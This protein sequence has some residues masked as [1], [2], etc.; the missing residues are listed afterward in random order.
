MTMVTGSTVQLESATPRERAR[1]PIL[2]VAPRIGLDTLRLEE[3]ARAAGWAPIV[4]ADS[5]RYSWAASVHRPVA[6]LLS[7]GSP[8]WTTTSIAA[9]STGTDS[10]IIV[11]G[12]LHPRLVLDCRAGGADSVVP[13]ET[14]D[15]ELLARVF[16]VVRRVPGAFAA[17]TRFLQ[18][19]DLR[20]DIRNRQVKKSDVLVSLTTT[21]FKVL[22][23]LMQR[24]GQAVASS[25]LIDKIWGWGAA[26]G[27]NTLR[28]FIRRL[29]LKLGDPARSPGLIVSVR[30]FGYKFAPDV[31]ELGDD[32]LAGAS[33][34]WQTEGLDSLAEIATEF[35]R[36]ASLAE[37]SETLVARLVGGG[38][39]DAVA[40]HHVTDGR[41]NLQAHRGL[42][43]SWVAQ[44]TA[45]PA[46]EGLASVVAMR[47]S[48]EIQLRSGSSQRFQ[49]TIQML[50]FENMSSTLFL[51]FDLGPAVQGCIGMTRRAIDPWSPGSLAYM[52]ALAAVYAGQVSARR[53]AVP[54]TESVGTA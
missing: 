2:V 23:Y 3:M 32:G 37:V 4:V 17:G 47:A 49:R 21:E 9:L 16:A 54:T 25:E 46:T 5:T 51:P 1:R 35:A 15:E 14:S 31:V 33:S 42:S 7:A 26:D 19:G 30:G 43:E 52:R 39:V 29:R 11:I 10:A 6:V 40:I 20:L 38:A 28:I 8:E 48:S 41:L 36:C 45:V 53:Q 12:N 24:P 34:S 13:R 27:S 50:R 22:A 44:A 18:S